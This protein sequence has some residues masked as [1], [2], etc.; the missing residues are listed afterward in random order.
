MDSALASSQQA[1][2]GAQSGPGD[3]DAFFYTLVSKDTQE[4]F[5]STK[6]QQFLIDQGY[7]FK[8]ITNLLDTAGTASKGQTT[9]IQCSRSS[10]CLW[11]PRLLRRSCVANIDGKTASLSDCGFSASLT[12]SA[13]ICWAHGSAGAAAL[14]TQQQGSMHNGYFLRL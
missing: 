12:A 5:Y 2:P 10:L 14:P 7:A 13:A 3:Y 1:K 8:V 6:R 11:Q 4:M 9:T